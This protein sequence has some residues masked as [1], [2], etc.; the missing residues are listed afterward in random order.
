LAIYVGNT[1]IA[2]SG[3]GGAAT[4][5]WADITDKPTTFAPSAH[6]HLWADITDKPTTFAPNLM[7]GS[8]VGGAQVG[9]GLA[10]STSYLFVKTASADGTKINTTGNTVAIDRTT[11]DA[12][13]ALKAH[14]HAI[15]DVTGLQTALDGK[16][17]DADITGLQPK[18]IQTAAAP[19]T[20][21]THIGQMAIDTTNRRTYI[22]EA[23]TAAD[24]KRLAETSY[25]DTADNAIL[26]TTLAGL[27]L[28]HGTQAAYDAIVTKSATTLY[29]IAG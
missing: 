21:P 25:V 23:G 5:A 2:T 27:S 3:G 14:S 1:Q 18:P 10:M 16:A 8:V 13:Y 17:D 22:A 15:A 4:T 12:W 6:T 20:T 26:N 7:S 29:F 28:W 11:V 9:N 19:T 24:W